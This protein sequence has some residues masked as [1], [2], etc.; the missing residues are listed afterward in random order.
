M[1]EKQVLKHLKKYQRLLRLDD[2]DIQF[3]WLPADVGD[4]VGETRFHTSKSQAYIKIRVG[5]T[6]KELLYTLMHE[7]IHV[8]LG[9]TR[10][11]EGSSEDQNL[12][13][14]INRLSELLICQLEEHCG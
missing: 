8:R 2:W 6:E 3:E 4:R 13:Q 5:L 12:E 14:G 10:F 7:L 1:T 9:Y 11:E